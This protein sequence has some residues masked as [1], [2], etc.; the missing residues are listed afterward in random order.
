MTGA[1]TPGYA[2]EWENV[3]SVAGPFC[4]SVTG[5]KRSGFRSYFCFQ[6]LL[7]CQIWTQAY[8]YQFFVSIGKL[9][10]KPGTGRDVRNVLMF[11]EDLECV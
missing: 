5:T 10:S 3:F 4:L 1:M 7:G 9:K 2:V 6:F 8:S 11:G